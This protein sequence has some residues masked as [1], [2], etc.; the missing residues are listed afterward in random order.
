MTPVFAAATPTRDT[1][2]GVRHFIKPGG[3]G[4]VRDCFPGGLPAFMPA[5]TRILRNSRSEFVTAHAHTGYD[6]FYHK[7]GRVTITETWISIWNEV[8]RWLVN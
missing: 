3:M 7:V 2:V 1:L 5:S 4:Q 8:T 6:G